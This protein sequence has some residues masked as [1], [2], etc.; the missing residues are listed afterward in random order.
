MVGKVVLGAP[1]TP[2]M[3]M[4][5][6]VGCR[7]DLAQAMANMTAGPWLLVSPACRSSLVETCRTHVRIVCYAHRTASHKGNMILS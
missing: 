1:A 7:H 5:V 4:C 6:L 3:D 2:T